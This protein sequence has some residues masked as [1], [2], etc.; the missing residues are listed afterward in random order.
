M[1]RRTAWVAATAGLVLVALLLGLSQA[2]RWL[3]IAPQS[4]EKADLI[5]A[6]GGDGGSRVHRAAELYRQGYAPRILLTGIEGG[7]AANR[8]HYLNWRAQY[9]VDRKVPRSALLFDE[10]SSNTWEEVNQ[11]LRLMQAQKM[12][13]VLVI[14]DAPHLRRLEWVFDR[15]FAGSGMEYRLIASPL[16]RWDAARWW[17]DELGVQYVMMEYTKLV[18]YW[19][20]H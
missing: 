3:E 4:P 13:R 8:L 16:Q 2:G 9:L 12:H 1:K 7:H 6:L 10:Q 20:A 19:F 14:S 11:L 17:R 15:V 5:V 18:Y